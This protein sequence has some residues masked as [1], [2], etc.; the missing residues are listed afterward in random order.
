MGSGVDQGR[1]FAGM[2]P[3]A[4]GARLKFNTVALEREVPG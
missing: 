2:M 3:E 1:E 4:L